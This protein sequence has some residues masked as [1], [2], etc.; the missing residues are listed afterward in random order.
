[1]TSSR[2]HEWREGE[3]EPVGLILCS[4]KKHQ[5]VELLLQHGPRRM[6]VSEYLTKLPAKKLFEERL[7]LYSRL[8]DG[9][10]T[11]DT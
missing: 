5:H 11:H 1:M 6:Q 10:S 2:T 7:R 8:M 9:R 4:S 3:N